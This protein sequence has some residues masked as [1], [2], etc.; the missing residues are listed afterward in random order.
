MNAIVA[1]RR[2]LHR[3][4]ELSGAE[5]ETAGRIIE[6]FRAQKPDRV[7][8]GLGGHGVAVVFAG[9]EPGPTVHLRCELDALPIQETNRFAHR[10]TVE[11]VSH[12]CGHDGHMAILAAVGAALSTRRPRRGRVV[13]LYQP[14]EENGAGAAA[15]LADRRFPEIEPDLSFALHNLPGYALGALLIR[16]GTFC[17]ASRG[18]RVRLRGATAHAAQP[19]TGVSPRLALSA[20][21]VAL[22]DLPASLGGKGE[23]AFA[24][25]VGGRL[26]ADDGF[27]ISP[28]EAEIRATL[29]SE[30]DGTMDRIVAHA[31]ALVRRT[32]AAHGLEFEIEY[33]DDFRATVNAARAVGIVRRAAGTAPVTVVEAPFRWSEDFGRFS[34]TTDVALFGMGAGEATPG[35]HHEA[36]DFPDALIPPG[37]DCYLG[38]VRECLEA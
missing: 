32:A 19:E 8:D 12:A 25:V 33:A 18:M 37:A 2:D 20:L 22:G 16:E 6:F 26:G 13:L 21:L 14:A 9:P 7:I 36:Y 5:T 35:L 15:V 31:E 38:I 24:T 10:S 11:G 3:H 29:R 23:R 4:P 17:C 1:L 27:G 28:G 34:A 30:T